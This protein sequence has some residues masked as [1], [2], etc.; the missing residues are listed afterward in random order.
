MFIGS[1]KV[2]TGNVQFVSRNDVKGT[3]NS[4]AVND[5]PIGSTYTVSDNGTL[6]VKNGRTGA[7]TPVTIRPATNYHFEKWTVGKDGEAT[8]GGTISDDV[9][10]YAV[11][12]INTMTITFEADEHGT[13]DPTKSTYVARAGATYELVK[14]AQGQ[15]TGAIKFTW[16]TDP[17]DGATPETKTETVSPIQAPVEGYKFDKWDLDETGTIAANSDST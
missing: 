5:I 15:Q 3:V 13:I 14:D 7:E 6:V 9:S 10:L 8:T 16:Q 11:F 17:D 12:S 2:S 1:F 4:S